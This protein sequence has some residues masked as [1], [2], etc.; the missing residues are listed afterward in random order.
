MASAGV[1]LF[2]GEP[3]G[4]EIVGHGFARSELKSAREVAL[5][6]GILMKRA[7]DDGEVHFAEPCSW[8]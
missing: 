6:F 5:G 8:G 2:A 4:V 7:V 3:H 1:R